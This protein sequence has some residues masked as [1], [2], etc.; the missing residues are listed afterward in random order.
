MEEIFVGVD[1][2]KHF[3]T[4]YAAD[5]QGKALC[6]GKFENSLENITTLLAQFPV[7]PTVVIEA[8]GSWMWFV[9]ALKKAGCV[10]MLAHPLKVRAIATS[11]IKTDAVD[12]KTLCHLLRSNLIPSSY[13]ASEEE[14]ENRELARG[15]IALV[16]DKTQLKNRI[17]AILTAHSAP[18]W[19]S[20]ILF[21]LFFR[22]IYPIK[23]MPNKFSSL[24][25]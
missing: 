23:G 11:M 4:Y 6:H 16:H 18:L 9:R 24:Y 14:Q 5:K 21:W 20:L 8:M 12:A 13:V 3:F 2:H 10:V 15:R 19:N 1:L 7:R 25:E 17:I 22:P